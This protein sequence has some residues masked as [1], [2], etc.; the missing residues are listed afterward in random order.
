MAAKDVLKNL[1]AFVDGRS[2]AGQLQEF[3]A[4]DL[5]LITED[6]RGGGMDMAV[7]IEM[8]MQGLETSFALISYDPDVLA[9]Y[10]VVEGAAVPFTIRAALESYDGTV[11]PVLIQMRGKI[12]TLARGTWAPG[13]VPSLTITM[14][15]DYYREQHGERLLHEVDPINMIRIHNGTDRLAAQRAALGL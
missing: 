11:T 13:Q 6:F 15:L 8:G 10:G 2:Y 12:T 4:P 9:L 3:N 7:A 1:N 5:S 14:R